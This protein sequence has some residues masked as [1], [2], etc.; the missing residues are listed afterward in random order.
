MTMILEGGDG[1]GFE[2]L[3]VQILQ[4]RAGPGVR[5]LSFPGI[6]VTICIDFIAALLLWVLYPRNAYRLRY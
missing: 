1:V 5:S 4:L 3:S 2:I 6:A